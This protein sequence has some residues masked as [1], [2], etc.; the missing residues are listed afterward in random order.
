MH[1][2][3]YMCWNGLV[4]ATLLWKSECVQLV[5]SP[6]CINLLYIWYLAAVEFDAGFAHAEVEHSGPHV[7]LDL[8]V[9]EQLAD[10]VL[11]I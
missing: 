8:P 3:V 1:C 7:V 2:F 9:I 4:N 5:S 6:I 10:V 11:K